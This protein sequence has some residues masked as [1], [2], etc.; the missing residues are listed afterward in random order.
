MIKFINTSDEAPYKVFKEKYEDS[1]NANQK[2]IEAICISSFSSTDNE[3]NARFVN[4]K[5]VKDKE[6]IFFSNA[7]LF[8]VT[9]VRV[10]ACS[11]NK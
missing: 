6:F 7:R 3:V 1:L 11:M 10:H 8:K 5:F 2:I 9:V 4:L